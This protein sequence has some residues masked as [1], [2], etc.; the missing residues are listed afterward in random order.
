MQ[1][2]SCVQSHSACY[3]SL[4]ALCRDVAGETE[5]ERAEQMTRT[6]LT[7]I[8]LTLFSQ[9]ALADDMSDDMSDDMADKGKYSVIIKDSLDKNGADCRIDT[10]NVKDKTSE[11]I[12]FSIKCTR[13]SY[14]KDIEVNCTPRPA[15]QCFVSKY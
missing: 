10:Y 14:L 7:A 15:A 4:Q 9:M 3:G 12:I 5:T 6:L 11:A 2:T 1:E 13:S 8:F